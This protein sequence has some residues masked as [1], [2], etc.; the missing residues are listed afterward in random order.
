M[1]ATRISIS[2]SIFL[3]LVVLAGCS[4]ELDSPGEPAAGMDDI[5]AKGEHGHDRKAKGCLQIDWPGGNGSGAPSGDSRLA[6]ASFVVKAPTSQHPARGWFRY[7]VFSD[8]G[9][10]HRQIRVA[11]DGVA[12]DPDQ[13]KV[14]FTGVVVADSK[15]CEGVPGGG[16]GGGH[17]DGCSGDD[18]GG[19]SGTHEEDE[20]GSGGHDSGHDGGCSGT[21]EEGGGCSDSSH[22]DGGGCSGDTGSTGGHSGASGRYCRVGQ[23]LVAKGHDGG[24][25]GVDTDGIT[26]KWF[27]A[28]DPDR[29][30]IDDLGSW[31]HLCRKAIISGNLIVGQGNDQ[32]EGDCREEQ[33]DAEEDD[34]D[35]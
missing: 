8:D 15:G 24:S 21:H 16:P 29:P 5:T 23:I 4:S 11:V 31:T 1:K 30:L 33:D 26:W 9:T 19:C 18:G 28:D 14:W 17:A 32:E 34:C 2:I 10:A 20:G 27:L 22:V 35:H 6:Q 12:V 3:L 25:P 7:Q 13:A